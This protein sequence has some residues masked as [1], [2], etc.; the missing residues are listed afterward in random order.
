MMTPAV[1]SGTAS[2]PALLGGT[3]V[4]TAPF[5]AWP[6]VGPEDEQAVLEVVRSGEWWY[7]PK[8]RQFEEVFAAFQGARY[9][10]T[11]CNG[12][13]AVELALKALGIGAGDEVLVPPYTFI[14][15]ASAVLQANAVPVFVDVDENTFNMDVDL[16]EAAITERT[17]AIV[18]VH[19]AGLPIDMDRVNALAARHG[20]KVVEDAAHAWG[21]QWNGKGVAA[22]GDLGT[23]SF[24][25]TKNLTSGEG[26]IVLTDNEELAQTLRSYVN[27][28]R[29]EGREWYEHFI[30]AGNYRL[31]EIQAALLLSQFTRLEAQTA[32]RERNAAI[33]DRELAEVPG[34]RVVPRDPRVTRRAWHLYPFRYVEAEFGGLPRQ[35]F[36]EALQA[37]GIEASPGYPKPLY[38][39]TAF[40]ELNRTASRAQRTYP[41]VDVDYTKVS[42][43]VAERLCAGEMVWLTHNYLLGTEEDTR[44]IVR[45]IRKTREHAEALKAAR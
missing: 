25:M 4:R 41:G 2:L 13:I 14:A 31:T 24:Q 30:I 40:R 10:V 32:L 11:C 3:P 34:I 23:F 29:I 19:F 8:V 5:P 16:I 42:C 36:L 26:G 15:T 37:E 38:R 43:P 28:G 20:L 7:G 18:V 22:L 1:P 9:G 6:V 44:D 33:L 17:R 45:A 27:V 12:T 35:R 21:S 39:Q